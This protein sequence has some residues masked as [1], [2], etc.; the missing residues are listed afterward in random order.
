[1]EQ[2]VAKS[3]GD[4][5]GAIKSL[6]SKLSSLLSGNIRNLAAIAIIALVVSVTMVL[7]LWASDDRF[8]PLYSV[9]SNYD[10][11]QILELLDES[12]IP[13]QLS[14]NDGNILVPEGRVYE[15]RKLLAAKGLKEKI[16][17]GLESLDASNSLG[18][19]QFME[20]VRYRHALEGELAKSIVTM[21]SVS[22]AR[23]HLSIAKDS[24]YDR[25]NS[26]KES[27]ASVIV[28]LIDSRE[29]KSGQINAIINLVSGAVSGLKPQNVKIVDQYGRLLSDE[30]SVGDYSYSS[31]KQR[32]YQQSIEAKLVRKATDIL[33]PIIGPSNFRVQVVADIDFTKREETEETFSDPL[34]RTEHTFRDTR[35]GDGVLGI[36][37]ALSNTPPVT[38]AEMVGESDKVDE[39]VERTSEYA[40][41]GK[42]SHTVYQQGVIEGLDISVV[43]NASVLDGRQVDEFESLIRVAV[44][45][46]EDRG[47]VIHIGSMPFF[48][49]ED[50]TPEEV[51]WYEDESITDLIKMVL[52]FL[53]ATVLVLK[54]ATPLIQML[55]SGDS[56][57]KEPVSNDDLGALDG[58]SGFGSSESMATFEAELP[59][60]DSPIEDQ[61]KHVKVIADNDA[62]RVAEVLKKWLNN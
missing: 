57:S 61:I 32:D 50:F 24:M 38:D 40:L 21:D 10:S 18:Q 6:F 3:S 29:F 62:D 2:E 19:S 15:V 8:R 7:M 33:T 13:Y 48:E 16:P 27:T 53:F 5:L 34:V 12:K 56:K 42:V 30:A 26:K 47:D 43:V 31:S 28:S 58:S 36:P 41:S 35:S 59:S 11:S 60:V 4:K 55:R 52:G 46:D 23:V 9:S 17:V 45:F 25:A 54:I 39:K 20:T 1:M 14:K 51:S 44:G 22:Y 37:G 49:I